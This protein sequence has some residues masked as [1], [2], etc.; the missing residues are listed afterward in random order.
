MTEDPDLVEFQ[1]VQD[2]DELRAALRRAQAQLAKSKAKNADIIAAVVQAAH[3]CYV[4]FGAAAPLKAKV[5]RRKPRG[6]AAVW[7]LTDW[8]TGKKTVSYDMA[9][10]DR[11]VRQFVTKALKITEIQRAAHPVREVTILFGGDMVENTTTFPGQ[12]WE[13]EAPTFDQVFASANAMEAVVRAALENY[14]RVQVICEPGNHG[15]VGG[16]KDGVPKGDNWDRVL[17]RIVEDRFRDPKQHWDVPPDQRRLMP[18]LSWSCED[19]WHQRFE[20]GNYRGVL[21]HGDEFKGFGGQ[22]PMYGILR[23]CNIWKGGVLDPFEDVYVGHYHNANDMA[24]AAGGEVL[25]TGSTE[26][27]NEMAREFVAASASP[28]QRL[29]FVDPDKGRTTA[30]YRIDLD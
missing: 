27:D 3:D 12:V 4:G 23:K 17:Y 13:I 15:R 14:E 11:R 25:M 1:D 16:K 6:E 26:S 30:K 28:S 29:V 22:I 18:G 9:T 2:K 19:H 20:I 10:M 21:V 24:L 8:Q 5:D 7:H